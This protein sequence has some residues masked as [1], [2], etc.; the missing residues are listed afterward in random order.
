MKILFS[1]LAVLLIAVVLAYTA[2]QDAGYVLIEFGDWTIEASLAFLLMAIAGAFVVLYLVLRSLGYAHGL[3]ARIGGWRR[4]RRERRATAALTRGFVALAQGRWSQAEKALTRY[5]TPGGAGVVNYLYAARAAQGLGASERRDRYL[6]QAYQS[7]PG[8]EVAIALTQAELQAQ[9][10]Q[11]EEALAILTRLRELD[12]KNAA[13]VRLLLRLY[14]QVHDWERL[15][16]LLPAA[17]KLRVIDAAELTRLEAGALLELLRQAV[18][19]ADLGAA[20]GVWQRMPQEYRRQAPLVAE[21][22]KGL[23]K[24]GR[25]DEAQGVLYTAIDREWSDALVYLYGTFQGADLG[26]QRGRAEAWLKAHENSWQ[27]L[28]TLGRLYRRSELW[29]QARQYLEACA[30]LCDLPEV[31][32]E[33]AAVTEQLGDHDKALEYYRRGVASM[34]ERQANLRLPGGDS[35]TLPL[36]TSL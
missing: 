25:E 30:A 23:I 4:N 19:R 8:A 32:Q 12:P 26:I 2:R 17:R 29:G 24:A 34:D 10:G 5:G 16:E 33:L 14:V 21:Y 31:Y 20:Q 9:Q 35:E 13:V 18:R 28:L 6:R 11:L 27:L 3:P 15:I 22:V 7:M 1:T 36:L